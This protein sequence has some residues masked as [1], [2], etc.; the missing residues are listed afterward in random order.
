MKKAE[1]KKMMARY[2]VF[3]SDLDSIFEFV[4]DL[5]E[6]RADETEKKYPNAF[7]TINRLKGAAYDVYDLIDYV[8]EIMEGEDDNE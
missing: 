1:F 5:L 6:A 3:E 7:N 4:V 2:L 8:D